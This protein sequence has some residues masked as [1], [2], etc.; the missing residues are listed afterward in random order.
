ME[1]KSAAQGVWPIGEGST[2]VLARQSAMRITEPLIVQQHLDAGNAGTRECPAFDGQP[3][4]NRVNRNTRIDR[5]IV[6]FQAKLLRCLDGCPDCV[7][8]RVP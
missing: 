5:R 6:D 8:A 2:H 3:S 7:G 1:G 4:G